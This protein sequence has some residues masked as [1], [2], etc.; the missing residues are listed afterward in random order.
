MINTTKSHYKLLSLK[1]KQIFEWTMHQY[2]STC[3]ETKKL[4][5]TIRK[6]FYGEF[7][8]TTDI[9]TSSM[10]GYTI[11]L[12]DTEEKQV[13]AAAYISP[14]ERKDFNSWTIN[15]I[16]TSRKRRNKG[17]GHLLLDRIEQI[18]AV[19]DEHSEKLFVLVMA[20]SNEHLP[21]FY[22]NC[23]FKS[24][25]NSLD[26]PLCMERK[27]RR[28]DNVFQ[29]Y[30]T[31]EDQDNGIVSLYFD[32]LRCDNIQRTSKDTFRASLTYSNKRNVKVDDIVFVNP[33]SVK[34]GETL[35]VNMTATIQ[36]DMY[37]R[38]FEGTK[39]FCNRDE[40]PNLN[41]IMDNINKI[42]KSLGY[43]SE[44]GLD[45]QKI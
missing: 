31:L 37:K 15:Y 17:Y 6:I 3:L 43:N 9:N 8:C 33:T 19:I 12:F 27:I 45:L 35:Q 38:F 40:S 4:N 29:I 24:S 30:K 42:A 18:L 7:T 25:N 11:F 26:E 22:E 5:E 14:D 1:D 36:K 41:V 20:N 34:I 32:P 2:C 28:H 21:S 44:D 39:Q 16:A 13:I 23:K 10:K